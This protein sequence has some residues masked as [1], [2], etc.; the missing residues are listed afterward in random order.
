VISAFSIS[1]VH[2]WQD[3]RNGGTGVEWKEFA[4]QEGL[5]TH[6]RHDVRIISEDIQGRLIK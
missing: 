3:D 6:T 5:I 2:R 4:T 1:I